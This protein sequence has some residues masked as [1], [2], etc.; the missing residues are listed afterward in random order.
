MAPA[1]LCVHWVGATMPKWY[2]PV[3]GTKRKKKKILKQ[4]LL[5]K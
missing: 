1:I 2:I 3:C 5:Q 4:L